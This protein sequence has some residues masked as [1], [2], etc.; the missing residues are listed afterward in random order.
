M[1]LWDAFKSAIGITPAPVP[2]PP[3]PFKPGFEE[4]Q[5]T[6]LN[7]NNPLQPI[8]G[9]VN[10]MY[11]ADLPTAIRLCQIFGGYR[12][13]LAMVAVDTYGPTVAPLAHALLLGDGTL[14]NAGLLAWGWIVN[15]D[16]NTA[17]AYATREVV[18][19]QAAHAGVKQ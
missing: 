12:P 17:L 5:Y 16:Y 19:D 13:V 11:Y 6:M 1:S 7:G 8:T 2:P 14:I 10:P 15:S 4:H 9:R 3:P 18:G